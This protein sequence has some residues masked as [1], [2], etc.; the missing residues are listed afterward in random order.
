MSCR[1]HDGEWGV[2]FARRLT[3]KDKAFGKTHGWA[4]ISL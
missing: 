3:L 4:L 1:E 2:N